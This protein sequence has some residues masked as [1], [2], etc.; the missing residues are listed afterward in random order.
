MLCVSGNCT[1][2]RLEAQRQV[3]PSFLM[4]LELR[5]ECDREEEDEDEDKGE[6][7][8]KEDMGECNDDSF[9]SKLNEDGAPINMGDG[10]Q[11]AIK[12]CDCHFVKRAF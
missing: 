7:E 4:A 12:T 8:D 6:D 11:A 9:E 2:E 5:P 1:L 10:M 3:F